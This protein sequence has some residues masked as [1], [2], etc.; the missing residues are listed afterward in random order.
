MHLASRHIRALAHGECPVLAAHSDCHRP[1][2]DLHTFVLTG[3][4]VP[5]N[6][7]TGI[8]TYL[9]L[10]EFSAR[11]LAGLQEGQVLACENVVDMF[12]RGHG[13]SLCLG[14]PVRKVL[15]AGRRRIAASE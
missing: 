10:E 9:Y 13:L 3:V 1:G 4:D 12:V 14:Q 2:E 5:G 8:E 11:V 6:P 7:S 15:V